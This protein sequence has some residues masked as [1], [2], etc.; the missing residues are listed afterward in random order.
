MIN[1]MKTIF[2]ILDGAAGLPD[3]FGK[4]TVLEV[5][6]IP[7]LNCF[8]EH[9]RCGLVYT[10]G[11]KIAPESDVA[12]TA[13]LGYD[14]HKYFTGRGPLEAYGA[15][16]NLENKFVAFRTNFATLDDRDYLI[17]RRAGRTVTTKEAKLLEKS[18]NQKVKLPCKFK[19]KSTIGHRGVLVL[20]GNFSAEVS[21]LDPAYKKV[22]TYGVA[23]DVKKAKLKP[24]KALEKK[25]EK[26]AL[27]LNEFV[28]QSKIVL[29]NDNVNK[30]RIKKGLLASNIILIRDAGNKLPKF[31]KKKKW[32]AV[33]S[34][35]LE[36]GLAKLAGM[37]V[38]KF[39][40]PE[41]KVKDI[42]THL[43]LGLKT[44][45]KYSWLNLKK[46][47]NKYDHFYIHFK[48][49]DIPGHDGLPE[50]KKKMIE[51]TDKLFFKKL[52]NLKKDFKLVVVS[53]H[54]T[55][56]NLKRHSDDPVAL[57]VYDGKNKDSVKKFN[58]KACKKGELGILLGK[59]LMK[60]LKL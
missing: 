33:A 23:K 47:W 12:V 19:Y 3:E 28:R 22:S 4:K 52:K 9:G 60:K 58:E 32:A 41:M 50:E 5:A 59:D 13:L 7:N 42:Y 43:Y 37:D 17:N 45:I 30:K 16:I 34:M 49:M 57:L 10:V 48:E 11:K 21:N 51:M 25:A 6:N 14:P 15:G 31:P 36:I 38:L 55:P 46:Y 20:Y 18:I 26:T 54:S 2:V 24:I 44:T 29:K 53:D 8:A 1:I 35:P 39:T 27:I 40:Y 56:C